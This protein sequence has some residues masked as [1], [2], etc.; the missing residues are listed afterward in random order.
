MD[1]ELANRQQLFALVSKK[2]N[3]FKSTFLSEENASAEL[4]LTKCPS[5]LDNTEN[6]KQMM[7]SGSPEECFQFLMKIETDGNPNKDPKFHKK[8]IDLYS[9]LS[10]SLP[11]EKHSKNESYAR[12]LIRFAELK[13][14]QDPDEARDDY[15]LASLN[16]K[17]FAFVHICYAQFELSQGNRKKCAAILE[18]AKKINAAPIEMVHLAIYNLKYGKT[19]LIVSPSN[20]E[21]KSDPS[22]FSILDFNTSN[23]SF[24]NAFVHHD[25]NEQVRLDTAKNQGNRKKCAA[26][27]EK[28][29]KINAAP[30]EMVHLAI[31]NLK[32]GKTQL[33]VSPSNK[34]NKSDPSHFSIL[35]FNTSNLSFANALCI[36][37]EMNKCDLILLKT[38]LKKEVFH[39]KVMNLTKMQ[40]SEG[41][42]ES[43]MNPAPSLVTPVSQNNL[44]KSD[45]LGLSDGM[46]RVEKRNISP[47]EGNCD[48]RAE[49]KF[50]RMLDKVPMQL[51]MTP[52]SGCSLK[53]SDSSAPSQSMKRQTSRSKTCQKFLPSL[54]LT[55]CRASNGDGD[56]F[57]NSKFASNI[58]PVS[59]VEDTSASNSTSPLLSSNDDTSVYG[60]T[61][62]PLQIN[63]TPIPSI[64]DKESGESNSSKMSSAMNCLSSLSLNNT[65]EWKIPAL[66]SKQISPENKPHADEHP[67]VHCIPNKLPAPPRSAS[68]LTCDT[69]SNK[70]PQVNRYYTPGVNESCLRTQI[71]NSSNKSQLEKISCTPL[72]QSTPFNQMKKTQPQPEVPFQ[73]YSCDNISINGK[74]YS[75]FKQIGKGG[76][77]KVFQVFNCRKQLFA[78]KVVDLEDADNQ[79]I[80]SYKNEIDHLNRLQQNCDQIIKLYDYEINEN[81]IY[82]LMECGHLDLNT[83]LRSKKAVDPLERKY[84]WKNML[85]AVYTIH[86]HGI[87]HSDLKPAN[88]VIVGATLKLIDFGIA[89]HIQPDVTSIVKDSQVGTLNY[90]PPEAIK[91]SSF[92]G[93]PKSKISP[94]SDVWS[95]GCI[96]YYMTYGKTPF[97]HITSQISKLQAIIDP[98]HKIKFPDI[99]EQ[100]LHDV[101]QKCLIR[102]PKERISIKELLEHPYV[103][104]QAQPGPEQQV[105][106]EDLKRIVNHLASLSS[107]RSLFRATNS[108]AQ[109][110]NS[111]KDFDV[112]DI[113]KQ[114]VT[115]DRNEGN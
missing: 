16:S 101:L 77:S 18:K 62:V 115:K 65:S 85:E 13:A 27:L 36:M 91:D 25:G 89:N 83:W 54:S 72:Q 38:S 113:M 80:E 61:S 31:Y 35:D 110:I 49:S 64:Q 73:T 32:Y 108:L 24:A 23:L 43:L 37:M 53:M 102:N 44:E 94:K 111:R 109:M 15:K 10:A 59:T 107:P 105:S 33:I 20:K 93:K 9:K 95:L 92:S 6:V 40:N 84:Y 87:V 45:A 86:Q 12:I 30:I 75:V 28:A 26:I 7:L 5:S 66:L 46:K 112:A 2:L 52:D 100:D 78:V 34:E 68:G 3:D 8:L 104:L 98:A 42:I 96:L 19:Q 69:P 56:K 48:W 22:H 58:S 70:I 114:D 17:I 79:T 99:S 39:Q 47:E 57:L 14:I 74:S 60:K 81:Y 41:F 71:P 50:R 1:E 11:P 106:A 21:N 76:S 4:N 97:Q 55:G 82:M 51:L 90:M 29:K 63:A 103:Q 88:F 67:I